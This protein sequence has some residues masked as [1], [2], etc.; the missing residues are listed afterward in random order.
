MTIPLVCAGILLSTLHQSSL[1]SLFLIVP[2]NVH[3]VVDSLLPVMFFAS[4][5]ALGVGMVIV[6]STLSNRA[7]AKAGD[8]HFG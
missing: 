3:L 6:E 2:N 7:L 1:G 4:A 8:F 5:V